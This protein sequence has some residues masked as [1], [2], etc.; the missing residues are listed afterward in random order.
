MSASNEPSENKNSTSQLDVRKQHTPFIDA[1]SRKDKQSI[2]YI[3][4]TLLAGGLAGC[5]AKTVI[6]PLDRVKIL[7]QTSNPAYE[8]FAGSFFGTFR[9]LS[10]IRRTQGTFG[11][12]Q[13][14]SATLLRIFPYA[15]IK[16]MSY[17]QLKGWLMPTKKHETPIKKFLAGSIAGCLSVFCSY[18]LDILRVRM[19]FDVRLNRPPS[20]LFETARAMYIEPSIFFPNAPKWI[21][22]FTNLFNFYR[23]FIPTI[24]GM[25]PYAGV[26]FLTYETLKSYML[27]HY[28]QYTLSNWNESSDLHTPIKP[29]LNA[30]TNLTIGGISGVIA[31]TFSYPFEVVR[32]HMQ[33][34]GKSALGHEHTSTFNTVKDIFRRKGFRGFWIGLSIGYIKVT[35]M[36]AVSFYSYEWLKL[37]LNID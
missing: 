15:A 16:F 1:K 24:Y 7:F 2:E 10:T 25:I 8:K 37:Q 3:S 5:A 31:Q 13:G 35:P 17:E 22:P 12:F 14:H 36:F 11:L 26:S 32:R 6:A 34:S 19:A 23:G 21:L 27:M 30:L 33:V 18:P 28:Q 9:A 29:I 4:K 20:G